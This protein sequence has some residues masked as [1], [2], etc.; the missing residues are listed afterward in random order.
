MPI[1]LKMGT[2]EMHPGGAEIAEQ[3]SAQKIRACPATPRASI[4]ALLDEPGQRSPIRVGWEAAKAHSQQSLQFCL[5]RQKETPAMHAG[6]IFETARHHMAG[7][8]SVSLCLC[9]DEP[10]FYDC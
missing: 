6:T 8:F 7:Y 2:G 1:G 10:P 4:N 3:S 5:A 9:G